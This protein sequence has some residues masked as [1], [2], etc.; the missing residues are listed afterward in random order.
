MRGPS[1]SIPSPFGVAAGSSGVASTVRSTSPSNL[2]SWRASS[3]VTP[4]SGRSTTPVGGQRGWAGIVKPPS[5]GLAEGNQPSSLSLAVHLE[6]EPI[7]DDWE[8]DS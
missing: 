6:N 5:S 4:S 1:T 2:N 8:E 7:P 3:A